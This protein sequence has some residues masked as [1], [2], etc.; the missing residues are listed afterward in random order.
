M[1]AK[2]LAEQL[3]VSERT[4]YRDVDA[5]CRAGVP[6][7][8]EPGRAGGLALLGGYRTELTG[9]SG[10]EAEALPFVGLDAAAAALGLEASA[11]AAR[12]K[13]LAA[14]TPASR[15]RANRVKECFYLDPADWYRRAVTPPHLRIIAAA[16]WANQSIEIDYESWTTRKSRMIDPLGLVLKAGHWY[17]VAQ[18]GAKRTTHIFRLERVREVRTLTTY[19]VRPKRFDLAKVWCEEVSRFEASLRREKALLRVAPSAMWSI[20]RL[21]AE[22][23]EAICAAQPD[24]GGWRKTSIWIEGISHA[25]G[26]LLGF[27]TDIEV[28]EPEE[29]RVELAQRA[30]QICSLYEEP[31]MNVRSSKSNR[32]L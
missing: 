5:L 9:L 10:G 21:G 4:I 30:R 15:S 11:E 17:L 31:A 3:E 26:L 32:P 7:I 20:D 14:L 18:V 25:A 29:L 19:F 12:L 23:A 2:A 13:L 16:A 24:Q 27:G 1:T 6:M 8:T 22:A 28:L